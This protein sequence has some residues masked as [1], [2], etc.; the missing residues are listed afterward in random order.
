MSTSLSEKMNAIRGRT[1]KTQEGF[2]LVELLIVI[3]IIGILAGIAVPLFLGE[4]EKAIQKEAL[5]NIQ[6]L[7]LVAEQYFAEN[8]CYYKDSSSN[9]A[10]ITLDGV[11]SIQGSFKGFKP[12]DTRELKFEYKIII[13]GLPAA[14]TFNAVATA[15]KGTNKFCIN[16]DNIVKGGSDCP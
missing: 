12:G 1:G 11:S 6:A 4:R 13:G 15:K 3:A 5:T 9:C 8:G 10:V 14:S 2:T 16:Q 7:R